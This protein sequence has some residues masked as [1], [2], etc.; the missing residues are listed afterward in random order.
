MI[1]YLPTIYEDEM[2]YSWLSRYYVHSGCLTSKMAL[3][4]ILYKRCN[5]PSKEFLGHLQPNMLSLLQK[6]YPLDDLIV[7]H[8][9]FPQ[10]ARFIP[11]QNKREALHHMVYDFCDAHHLFPIPPREESDRFLKY[12]PLCVK[13]DRAKYGECYWHRSHQLRNITVCYKHHCTLKSSTVS[14]KSEKTF[15]FCPSEAYVDDSKVIMS[16]NPS[17]IAY[18]EYVT[19]I[20]L[21]PMDY[22]KDNPISAV[23]YHHLLKTPYMGKSDKVRHTKELTDD[24]ANYY[25]AMG[26]THS[27]SIYTIQRV[28]LGTKYDFTTVCQ[29]AYFLRIPTHQLIHPSLTDKQI[30]QENQSHNNRNKAPIDWK[31]LDIQLLPIIKKYCEKT[32]NG[33][34]D[35]RPKRI[36]ERMLYRDLGIPS[37]QLENLPKCNAVLKKYTEPYADNWARQLVWAYRKLKRENEEKSFY[38]SDI[39]KITSVKKKNI[40]RIIPLL[41]KYTNQRI[42]DDIVRLFVIGK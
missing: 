28:L 20:F 13:D 32:Y 1:A 25:H 14:A 16:D 33:T 8:T 12:C 17:M 19:D 34:S 27:S 10:Y 30:Q 22:S 39:R 24:I 40:D 26:L 41:P 42:V 31:V 7:N 2:V 9:M 35:D 37:H 29:I 36:S 18:T 6:L 15:T 38:W 11:L 23:F 5:N 21:S 3:D 4:D